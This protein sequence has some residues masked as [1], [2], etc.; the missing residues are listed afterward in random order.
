MTR[1]S[2]EVLLADT[3]K[4]GE[5]AYLARGRL[6]DLIAALEKERDAALAD[7]VALLAAIAS[8]ELGHDY[9]GLC[10]DK[11]QPKARDP[12]CAACRLL[13]SP[14]PGSAL[15]EEHRK[16][17]VRARNEGLE[18]AAKK[19][20]AEREYGCD[21]YLPCTCDWRQRVRWLPDDIRAL[22][23]PTPCCERDYDGDG[24][25]DRHPRHQR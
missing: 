4:G 1:D 24:N 15:L 21:P 19:A 11:T 22:K 20:D 16:A 23:E 25:C 2:V 18:K 10:P 8:E 12:E 6:H 9:Q 5:T 7:N 14:H 3:T 13:D 17:L